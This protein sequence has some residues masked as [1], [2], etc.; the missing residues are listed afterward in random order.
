LVC[1][2]PQSDAAKCREGPQ[3]DLM[4]LPSMTHIVCHGASV[5]VRLVPILSGA[6]R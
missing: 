6:A 3:A 1:F 4:E 5:R 2:A